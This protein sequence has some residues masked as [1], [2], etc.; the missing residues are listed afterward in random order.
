MA[1]VRCGRRNTQ[2]QVSGVLLAPAVNCNTTGATVYT[3]KQTRMASPSKIVTHTHIHTEFLFVFFFSPF[4]F[5]TICS[6]C[7][8]QKTKIKKQS[9]APAASLG[10]APAITSLIPPN[11][12]PLIDF[13]GS[14]ALRPHMHTSLSPAFPLTSGKLYAFG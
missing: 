5:T 9:A 10:G 4:I 1:T 2:K 12:P 3:S 7:A 11:S 14:L 6:G 8:T 13:P